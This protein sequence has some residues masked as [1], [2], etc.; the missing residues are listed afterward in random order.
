MGLAATFSVAAT[1]TSLQYQWA[2]NGVAISGAAASS[3]TTPAT[4]FADGGASFTVS[5][6]NARGTVASDAATLTVTARAP[7]AGDLRF[8]QVDAPSTVN[9]WGTA[10]VAL[11]TF[12]LA[13]SA[14]YFG[15]S[16]GTPF[17]VGSDGN[18]STVPVTDGTG[19][20]W[21][22]SQFPLNAASGSGLLVGYAS[23]FI[24]NLQSDLGNTAWPAFLSVRFWRAGPPN[25]SARALAHRSS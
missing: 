22:F 17:Y 12:L 5:V 21:A 4:T 14:E 10:G 25:I 7:M 2:K 18:C 6:T 8:Q 23:D 3:Y 13:R 24:A 15:Q 20:A 19:C 9:G 1:G 11:S 16:L